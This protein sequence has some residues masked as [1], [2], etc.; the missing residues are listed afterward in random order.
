MRKLA[1]FITPVIAVAAGFAAAYFFVDAAV[2]MSGAQ[3]ALHQIYA[4]VRGLNAT[5]FA[6]LMLLCFIW[7]N[8]RAR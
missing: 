8:T 7:D 6:G 5:L 1:A 4:A 2:I 3:S